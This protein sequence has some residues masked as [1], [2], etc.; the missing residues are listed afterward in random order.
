MADGTVDTTPSAAPPARRATRRTVKKARRGI[1]RLAA[2]YWTGDQKKSA[3]LLSVART[4]TAG[5][6]SYGLLFVMHPAFFA[7]LALCALGFLL[8]LTGGRPRGGMLTAVGL[9]PA[10]GCA[11]H[12]VHADREVSEP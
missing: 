12:P 7:A 1:A 6:D 5:V 9:G 10:L 2:P 4:S 3:W 8:E 11:E